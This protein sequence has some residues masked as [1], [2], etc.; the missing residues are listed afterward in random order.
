MKP[1][2]GEAWH[3]IRTR[4]LNEADE[5]KW[6]C[7]AFNFCVS[8]SVYQREQEAGTVNKRWVQNQISTS[9]ARIFIRVQESVQVLY[10][11]RPL[12]V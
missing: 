3:E 1:T 12:H 6:L 10:N 8:G 4:H 9:L 11:G 7:R 2:T 5:E